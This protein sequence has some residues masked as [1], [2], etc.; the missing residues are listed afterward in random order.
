MLLFNS[1]VL[2]TCIRIP[3]AEVWWQITEHLKLLRPKIL[4]IFLWRY[5][6]TYQL[7][8]KLSRTHWWRRSCWSLQDSL[9]RWRIGNCL[10]ED[11]SN[12]GR[13]GHDRNQRILEVSS[14]KS[15]KFCLRC[16]QITNIVSKSMMSKSGRDKNPWS[17]LSENSRVLLPLLTKFR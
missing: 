4:N 6:K 14:L 2:H 16:L 11:H 12:S 17:A 8:G 9:R 7:R 3:I 13:A 5:L 15:K 1:S 10:S